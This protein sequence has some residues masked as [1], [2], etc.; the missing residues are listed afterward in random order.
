MASPLRKFLLKSSSGDVVV[1]RE[2]RRAKSDSTTKMQIMIRSFESIE[3]NLHW[4]LPPGTRK[5]G[6]P[7]T[8]SLFTVLKS[9]HVH[10]KAREQFQM[11]INKEMLVME[12]KR[13]E[14]RKKF[15]WLKRQ[16]IFGAQFEIMFSF[17]TRLDKAQLQKVLQP[18]LKDVLKANEL[19]ERSVMNALNA[20]A[21]EG[22]YEDAVDASLNS[23]E[24]SLPVNNTG[25]FPQGLSLMLR[26]VPM[27]LLKARVD[28][29][30]SRAASTQLIE[31]FILNNPH[32]PSVKPQ[33][34]PEKASEYESVERYNL[35]KLK[36]SMSEEDLAEL[37]RVTNELQLKPPSPLKAVPRFSLKNISRKPVQIPLEVGDINGVNVLKHDLITSDVL[38]ADLAFDMSSL[39]PELLPLV[40]LFCRSLLEMGTKDLNALQ[41]SQLIG[42]DTGGISIYPFTS[43]KQGSKDLVSHVIVRG[44]AMS[45]NTEDLFKLMTC[46]LKE[47][48]FI[49][50]KRFKRFVSESKAKLENQLRESGYGLV[51][52]RLNAKLNHAGWIAEQMGG[53]SYLEFLKD[54]EG[55][56]E[57]EWDEIS[58]SLEEIRKTLLSKKGCLINLTSDGK[59][60][61][62][63]EKY[64]RKLISSLPS[65]SPI[66]SSIS[67]SHLP[68]NNEAILVP[69]QVNYVGKAANIYE[70]GYQLNGSAYVISKYIS[71]TW[72]WDNIRVNGGAFGGFCDFDTRS[73]VLS[74]LSYRDPNLLKTLDVYDGT[75]EFL[76]GLEL[77]D[78]AL[79]KAIIG[80]IKDLDTYQLPDAKGYSS[81]LR[82][83][84]GI[85]EEDRQARREEIL[86]T[87]ASDFKEFADIVDTIKDKGVVVAVASQ[88]D[89]DVANKERS[90]FFEMKKVL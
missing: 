16:R 86:S 82:Y 71:N 56:I 51:A 65:T 7:T 19:E 23:V 87:T 43:S 64:I 12:T 32:R 25:S 3:K 46:V 15:F 38:Y 29:E 89:A 9:P 6:L 20:L 58:M 24:S 8:R 31:K 45:A 76:R 63:A 18:G 40:P 67:N 28:K 55:K 14:L 77:D 42:R 88:A 41:L 74:F 69:T 57:Q 10:K 50:P 80:T 59:N 2:M 11:K 85:S 52:T 81:L 1:R 13:H 27:E 79:E 44:K 47:A 75:S 84:S 60:L 37:A 33:T 72:L 68:S 35:E 22:F 48:E 17:K 39:K 21:H 61:K 36:A 70:N 78:N 34:D 90:N 73:G 30:G 49:N 62:V 83:I 54:L 53:I 66:T 5:I 26:S 4:E